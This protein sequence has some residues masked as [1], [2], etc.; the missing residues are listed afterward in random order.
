MRAKQTETILR[1]WHIL[2][3]I[4]C[5]PFNITSTTLCNKLEKE[6]IYITKRTIERDLQT[7]S[8][9]FPIVADDSQ[10]PFLWSWSE[11]AVRLNVPGLSN[12]EALTFVMVEQYLSGLLPATTLNQLM[13][14]FKAAKNH[15]NSRQKDASFRAWVDKVRVLP[16]VQ[17]LLASH[18]DERVQQVVYEALLTDKQLRFDYLKRGANALSSYQVHPLAVVQRGPVVYLLAKVEYDEV[19]RKFAVHRIKKAEKLEEA[20]IPPSGYA[21]DDVIAKGE[22][23]FATGYNISLDVTFFNGTGE[24]LFET[25]LTEHQ[26]LNHEGDGQ[27][28]LQATVAETQELSWWLLGFGDNVVVNAPQSLRQKMIQTIENMRQTYKAS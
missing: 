19:L 3:T 21:I 13:P 5:Y 12:S 16:P 14:Y 18:V 20:V 26:I 22:F 8:L 24:H 4:P 17:T 9:L 28:R 27:L 6:L 23:G 1:H 15:L 7:L 2:R 25:P 10:K 11:E